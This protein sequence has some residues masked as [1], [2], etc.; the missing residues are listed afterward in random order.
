M[1]FAGIYGTNYLLLILSH[2]IFR[3]LFHYVIENGEFPNKN[4]VQDLELEYNVCSPNVAG[5]R[6]STVIGWLKW[7]FNLPNL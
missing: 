7:I 2:Q 4:L 6:A 1:T 5:R 3:D